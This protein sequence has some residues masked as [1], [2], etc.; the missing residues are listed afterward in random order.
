MKEHYYEKLLNIRTRDDQKTSNQSI[1]YHPYEPTPYVA[2]E[3]L[4]EKYEVQSSDHIVDFGCGK[5]RLL[6][7]LHHT[8]GAKVKGIE[9]NSTFYEEAS[10]NLKNYAKRH[11]LQHAISLVNSFA[12]EYGI[13][14]SDN[15][16]YFF[17]PFSIK[18]FMK[19]I[20]NILISVE[21]WP[22]EV[23]IV[24]YYPSEDYIY[25]LENQTS[26][27]LKT[28]IPVEGFYQQ[29]QNERFL[30]YR[31]LTASTLK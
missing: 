12:E 31:G 24:L 29:N 10:Q 20:N 26:F 23:E 28:E 18:V 5:G 7:F 9:M 2:L 4:I 17:N 14:P 6:F 30:V 25:Y 13:E 21:K 11:R 1:H 16:F 3:Q 15:R 27:E 22:R 8:R 19:V